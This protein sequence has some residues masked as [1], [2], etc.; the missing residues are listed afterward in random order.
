MKQFLNFLTIASFLLPLAAC[1]TIDG[2]REDI[3]NI[4]LDDFAPARAVSKETT[5]SDILI[6]GNCPE[7]TIVSDLS[8]LNEFANDQSNN[9]DN[10]I[11]SVAMTNTQTT[12]EFT[13][14]SVTV[15]LELTM[16]ATLGPKAGST[17]KQQTFSYPFFV[18]VTTNSGQILAKEIFAAGISFDAGASEKLYIETLRQIIPADNRLHASRMKVMIGFQLT[19]QQLAYNRELIEQARIQAEQAKRQAALA[20]QPASIGEFISQKTTQATTSIKNTISSPEPI[21][22][23]APSSSTASRAGPF[24]IFKTDN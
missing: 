13:D 19:Q 9:A 1:Q 22:V 2:L 16:Q 23:P 4:T 3:S 10:L 7:V 17:S 14:N 21:A 12:C 11:S 6:D 8:R 5:Q 15:D 20:N 18:A 24:D